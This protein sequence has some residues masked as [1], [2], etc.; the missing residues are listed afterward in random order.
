MPIIEKLLLKGYIDMNL[1]EINFDYCKVKCPFC[2]EEYNLEDGIYNCTNCKKTFR[3]I[4]FGTY[5]EKKVSNATADYLV[6]LLTYCAKA[7]KSISCEERDFIVNY[8]KSF[9]INEDQE[10]WVFAQYDYARLNDYN[11]NIIILLKK[12]ICQLIDNYHLELDILSDMI[13]IFLIDNNTLNNLQKEIIND[14][15]SIFEISIKIYED[16]FNRLLKNKNYLEYWNNNFSSLDIDEKVK[17]SIF[18]RINNITGFNQVKTNN[19][20]LL[21]T[22]F[23]SK[24]LNEESQLKKLGYSSTIS[25]SERENILKNKAIPQLGKARVR[26]HIE[27]LINMNKNKSTMKNSIIEWRYDLERLSRM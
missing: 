14:Y 23:D 9:D 18:N 19:S 11:K 13:S 16:E 7:D 3:K 8:I 10:S 4:G 21:S 25:R 12:S 24:S 5:D 6:Q 26:S 1:N 17:L 22:E 2:N 20:R 15:L 27:W